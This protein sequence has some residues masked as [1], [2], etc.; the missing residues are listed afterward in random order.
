MT[1]MNQAREAI[2]KRFYDAW[3]L[4]TPF[5][6]DNEDYVPTAN[7]ANWV[8]LSVR[9]N[10][11]TQETLGATGNRRFLRSGSVFIQVFVQQDTGTSRNDQLVTQARA[12]YEGVSITGTTVRFRDV[13]VTETGPDG[14]WY[15]SLI[16]AQFDYDETK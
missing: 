11:S 16:E 5:T 9:H 3:G 1:T 13:I 8:R 15:Q 10:A 4:T 14:K 2:Y 12:I 7:T 6:F